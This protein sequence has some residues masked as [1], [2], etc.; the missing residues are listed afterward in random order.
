MNIRIIFFI[1]LLSFS[2]VT[3]LSAMPNEKT[4][5][6]SE[7]FECLESENLEKELDELD[8]YYRDET[9]EILCFFSSSPQAELLQKI[10]YFNPI[11]FKPPIC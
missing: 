6:S 9:F 5:L 3:E 11:S 8:A 4:T 10:V 2:F 1:L 7:A